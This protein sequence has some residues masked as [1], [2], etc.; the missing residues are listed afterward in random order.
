MHYSSVPVINALSDWEHP[1]QTLAD[2]QTIYQHKGRM[3][4]L[5]IAFIGRWQQ[6]CPQFVPGRGCDVGAAFTIASPEGYDL[7]TET[8]DQARGLAPGR[9]ISCVRKPADGV[10][11][12]DV[13]Y[14]D[15]WTSMGQEKDGHWSATRPSQALQW[16]PT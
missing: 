8:M 13:V 15:V 1:C 10:A 7:D 11:G 4:G 3:E 12:A 6:R 16:M 5:S 14:T 2:L 9:A